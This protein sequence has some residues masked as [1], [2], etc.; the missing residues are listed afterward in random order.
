MRYKLLGRSGLRISELALGAMSFGTDWGWGVD[1]VESR[2]IFDLFRDAGGNFVDTAVNYS[3]G[4]SE[5]LLGEF[6][7]SQR[8]RFVVAT[9]FSMRD[10]TDDADD[11][12]AG[13]NHRKN[14]MR[15]IERSLRQL[16]TDYIDLLYLHAWDF[17]TPVDEV[18]RT[19][20]DLVT[21]GK[22]RYLG[23]SDTPAWV[24]AKSN[25]IAELRGWT[26]YVAAQFKYS[27]A[28]RDPERELIPMAR[29]EDMAMCVWGVL[30]RGVLT[31]QYAGADATRRGD[32]ITQH[33]ARLGEEVAR[34]A[35]EHGLPASQIAFAW[36]KERYPSGPPVIP[37][38][39]PRSADQM[40]HMI[41]GLDVV[42]PDEVRTRLD[43]VSAVDLGF[44]LGFLKEPRIDKVL[45]GKTKSLI[46]N[47]RE[48][49]A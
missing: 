13:G 21:S 10:D 24:I 44:P 8:D 30:D 4:S 7:G 41:A 29:S 31:G 36:V 38:V 2:R 45:F 17:T 11:P 48:S 16:R 28:V 34:L 1:A 39:G 49:D 32:A 6:M 23:I 22:V 25:T 33:R 3:N 43:E 18:L 47:H 5:R 15:S 42:L 12:N 46:D 40:Q 20:D 35:Q 27:L 14:L 9:K 19:L 37:L 26:R